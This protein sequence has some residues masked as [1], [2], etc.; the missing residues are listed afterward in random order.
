MHKMIDE[1]LKKYKI[2]MH[3]LMPNAIVRINVF[4]VDRAKSRCMC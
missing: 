4:Y 1:V 2:Y 3:Q